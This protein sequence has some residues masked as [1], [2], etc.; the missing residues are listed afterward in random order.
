[1]PIL[2]NLLDMVEEK[3]DTEEGVAWFSSVHMTYA[4]GQVP[5]HQLPARQCNFQ[6]IGGESTGRYRFV[7]GFYCL[8]VMP[9]KFQKVMDIF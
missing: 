5:F 8:S 6:I 2:D 7:T 9:T 3:L 4:Y 1:M